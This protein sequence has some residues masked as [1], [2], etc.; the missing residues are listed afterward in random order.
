MATRGDFINFVLNSH[1]NFLPFTSAEIRSSSPRGS[2]GKW[3]RNEETQLLI[4]L[5]GERKQG[6][7]VKLNVFVG[8]HI[9]GK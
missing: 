2:A 7:C 6:Y 3:K 9:V 8:H 5:S 1:Y 4:G